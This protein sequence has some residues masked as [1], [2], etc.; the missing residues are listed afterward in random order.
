MFRTNTS[1]V[2]LSSPLRSSAADRKATERCSQGT[3]PTD[4]RSTAES[5]EFPSP[6]SPADPSARLASVIV[7]AW[8]SRTKTSVKSGVC[9][10]A[11]RL[12]A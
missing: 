10:S 4:G 9:G 12:P 3:I 8:M 2:A 7:L 11:V 5:N 6:T 1:K